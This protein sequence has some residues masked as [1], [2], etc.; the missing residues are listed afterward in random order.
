MEYLNIIDNKIDE[1]LNNN[2]FY[3]VLIILLIIY[4][5]FIDKLNNSFVSLKIDNPYVR[6]LLV[7]CILYF[8]TKDIRVSLLLL[9]MFLIELDKLNMEDIKAELV[10][11]MVTD[12]I[13]EERI[14]KLEKPKIPDITYYASK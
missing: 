4:C 3:S 14:S 12:S 8:A 6:I 7:L 11:L 2:L 13:L 1:V 10:T 5:T 9:L